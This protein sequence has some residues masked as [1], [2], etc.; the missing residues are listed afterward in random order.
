MAALAPLDSAYD[1]TTRHWQLDGV[2][3]GESLKRA[4]QICEAAFD[5]IVDKSADGVIVMD[6]QGT[7]YFAN[8]AAESMLGRPP[9]ELL[10]ERFAIP[11]V[12]GTTVDIDLLKKGV[13]ARIAAMRV[14]LTSW[15][16]KQAYLV[17]LRDVTERKQAEDKAREA[18][19][20]RDEFLAILSHELRNPLAAISNAVTV[21]GSGDLDGRTFEK[22]R[23][24]I[25][26][27]C[28]QISRLLEDL[29]DVSR[30]TRRKIELRKECLDLCSV[31]TDA[32]DAV[33]PQVDAARQTLVVKTAPAPI[34]VDGDPVRLQ[35][36][37]VNL[38]S[39]ASKYSQADDS[40]ELSAEI[41][42]SEAVIRVRDHG[43]GLSDEMLNAVFEPFVQLQSSLDR[44]EGG[45]G[46]GLAIVEG[47][48]RLHGGAVRAA[49]AGKGKGSEFCVRL[50]LSKSEPKHRR[51]RTETRSDGPLSILIIE[52]NADVR[53]MLK[54]LL[55]F[56]GHRV[57]I[58][59][60]GLKGVELIG[61]QHPDV[62]L[63]DIGLPGLNGYE[64]ARKIRAD[65]NCR[66]VFLV[67]LTGYSQPSDRQ[68]ALSSGFHA[69]LAKPL[70]LEQLRQ[71]LAVV[72]ESNRAADLG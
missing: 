51:I 13:P 57:E 47:L 25:E 30:V 2:N 70:D 55:E 28:G 17:T 12:P 39:N 3:L 69:H 21:L 1:V 16:G 56:A 20:R 18:V 41:D 36:I 66:D 5:A 72:R 64:L 53:S 8:A 15:E 23:G 65:K 33:R 54:T 40:I 29:L 9:G 68:R 58:A 31:I 63:V 4:L 45:L 27:Q 62:A 59:G 60:D 46:L 52:D 32:V 71:I 50:P 49:S 44:A 34:P 26:R 43:I 19:R 6:P 38:L 14:V 7:I 11:V 48:V 37:L 24:V 35:Q 10:G 22:A 67:A 61:L 42:Q